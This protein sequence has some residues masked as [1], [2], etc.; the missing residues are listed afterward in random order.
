MSWSA[1]R[2]SPPLKLY[3]D[4]GEEMTLNRGKTYLVIVDNDEWSNFRY[5]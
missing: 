3:T 4:S 5:Q 1:L 2:T